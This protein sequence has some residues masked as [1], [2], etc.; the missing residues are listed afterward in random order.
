MTCR[1]CGM[2]SQKG[3]IEIE[4]V[5]KNKEGR[6]ILNVYLC[7]YCSDDIIKSILNK[8]REQ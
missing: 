3:N 6:E 1:K 5:I 8:E 4:L 2:L 7:Q